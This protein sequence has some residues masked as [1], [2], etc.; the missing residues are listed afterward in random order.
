MTDE[1]KKTVLDRISWFFA[2]HRLGLF[3]LTLVIT[4]VFGVGALRIKGEVIIAELLP[5]E[6]PYLKIMDDFSRVFGS[7]GSFVAIMVKANEG[8]I[9]KKSIL[10]KVRNITDEVY[11]WVEVY[12]VL[13]VSIASRS[14]KVVKP[15]AEGEIRVAPLMWPELPGTEEE[16]ERLK[17]AIFSNPN[18]RGILASRDGTAAIIVTQFKENISYARAFELLK[19]ID[20]RYGD[21]ETSVHVVGYPMMMGWIYSLRPQMYHVFAISI[22]AVALVLWLIFLNFTGMISPLVNAFVLTIW[23]LGFIG[24]TGINFNPLLY[25]LAF[26]VGSRMIGNSHQIAYRYFEELHSSGNDRFRACYETMRTMFIPNFAAV[27]ADVA[28]FSV[29]LIAKIVLMRHLAIIMSF[30]MATILMTGFLVPTVCSL[31][32][33]RVAS[34]RWAKEDSRTGFMSRVMVWMTEFAIGPRSKYVF[35]LIM[36]GVIVFSGYEFTRLKIGDPT[37]GSPIFYG[38]H[39]YN[40]DQAL[41]DRTFDAS[42]EDFT[43]YYTGE[44]QSVYQPAVLNTF[45][46]FDR[47]MKARLPDIYKSSESIIGMMKAVN[48]IMHDGDTLWQELPLDEDK[49]TNL[50]GWVKNSVDFITLSRYYDHNMSK[51]QITLFFSDHTS[52]NLLRIRDAAYGFFKDHPMKLEKGEFKLAGGR[53]GM[54]IAV[55]E[56]MKRSHL[57]IDLSVY[58]GIF[59]LCAISY[60][61]VVA[62]LMLTLPLV[63]ANA[64]TFAYMA[65]A[66]IGLSINTLPVAAIGAGLGVD[67]AIYLYSRTIEEFPLQGR[68]WYNT[69]IQSVCTCGKAVVYTGLTVILPIITWYF[70]SDMK[71]QAEV[72]LFLSMIM[73]INVILCLT[74]HPFLIYIIKPKWATRKA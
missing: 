11:N 4:G 39:P 65:I 34:E 46:A 6:H 60:R 72:G 54:E 35:G 52:D 49:L 24:F 61:S 57:L 38:N 28:G 29:L 31:L 41:V 12:R 50:N 42:S 51:A 69:I 53:I 74:L 63:L 15:G 1:E 22:A 10:E 20:K 45:E 47:H 66:N 62:G 2:R 8:D 68:D 37:P 32:P 44:K 58:L 16:M 26:L 36:I 43:L 40:Q 59:L 23:G 56:E 70:L 27:A 33:L 48:F 25:V 64:I 67:F 55:N 71:F 73:G 21:A 7:G 5:Y 17:D 3:V 19:D 9:F 13:T 14:T 30:W 18:L